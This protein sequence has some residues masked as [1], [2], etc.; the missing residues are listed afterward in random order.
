MDVESA[1]RQEK[2]GHFVDL[3]KRLFLAMKRGY[4]M[5]VAFEL[6]TKKG[7]EFLHS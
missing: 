7:A 5:E 6:V 2:K 1:T 3:D 4:F